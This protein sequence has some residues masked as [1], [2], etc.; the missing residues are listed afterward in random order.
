MQRN[1]QIEKGKMM[2]HSCSIRRKVGLWCVGHLLGATLS[3]FGAANPPIDPLEITLVPIGT[4]AN[5]APYDQAA[6]KVV[7]HDPLTQ[8]LYVANGR[9]NRVE[10]IDI[11]DPTQPTKIAQ[12][13]MNP[14]GATVNG[15]AVHDDVLAVAVQNAVKTSPGNVVFF[16]RDLQWLNTVPVGALPDFIVFS[17]DGR[18]V[19]TANEGEPNTYNNFGSE[20]NGPSIDPEGSITIIDLSTGVTAPTVNTATFTAFN[21][22]KL[23]PSIRIYGP[24]ATVAQDLEP[25][26][27]AISPDSTTAYVTLQENNAMGIVDIASATVTRLVG[28][29]FKDFSQPGCGLDASDK[30]NKINIANWPVWGVYMPDEVAAY[31]Y[32]GQTFLVMAN[33][34][35]VRDYPGYTETVEVKALTLDPT[36]FPNAADLKLTKNLGN[37]NVSKVGGDADGDGDYD[38]LFATGGRSFTIRT[39]DGQVAF[40]SGDQF[41]QLTATLY[42]PWFNCSNTST[43]RDKRSVSKGP[44]PEGVALGKVAGRQLAFIGFERIGGVIVYD[45]SDPFS[46]ELV[47][48]V[49]TRNFSVAKTGPTAGDLGPEGLKFISADDSPTGKPLLAVANEVSGSVTLFQINKRAYKAER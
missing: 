15:V 5:G 44:E 12:L 30:D 32:Q 14:Y 1:N 41:E 49:N 42:Q 40:D 10:V 9:D 21:G 37:L 7:T 34:G 11:L 16:D 36:A 17:P 45:V 43:N 27:I 13:D 19:L 48:Y 25:E 39:A 35:D 3:A 33:E 47:D 31:Q 24:N 8:R 29:G 4:Y 23:D 18:W 28:L 26:S 46:P 22:A 38:F 2:K 20:T 6:A